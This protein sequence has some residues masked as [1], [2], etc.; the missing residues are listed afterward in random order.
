[1]LTST[2]NSYQMVKLVTLTGHVLLA[3]LGVLDTGIRFAPS[4][5][6][7]TRWVSHSSLLM[8]SSYNFSRLIR[9]NFERR[10]HAC[11]ADS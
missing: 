2:T 7:E 1:M 9:N 4:L 11:R 10:P 8:Q 3:T 6:I 5:A